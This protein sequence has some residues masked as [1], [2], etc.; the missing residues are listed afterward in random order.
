MKVIFQKDVKGV[1]KK[2]EVK[3][4]A[5]GY[6]RNFLAPKKLAV[7]A[8]ESNLTS[9]KMKEKS[10]EKKHQEEVE[11]A[12]E[13]AAKLEKETVQ[14]K[15]KAGEGGRL[16]GA[17]TNKQ[18]AEALARKKYSIDKRKIVMN[19]PIRTIGV[20]NVPVKLH[21]EVTATLKVQVIEE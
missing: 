17:V 16:F 3:E 2:G 10:K 18:V 5:E 19:E 4:V 21:P 11:Q 7:E 6:F 12:R 8:S 9:H 20:T 1:G 14:I 15:A 13:L